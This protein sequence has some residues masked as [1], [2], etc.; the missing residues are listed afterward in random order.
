MFHQVPSWFQSKTRGV[1][2]RQLLA[3]ETSFWQILVRMLKC[4]WWDPWAWAQLL[5]HQWWSSGNG[6]GNWSSIHPRNKYMHDPNEKILPSVT[7]TQTNDICL[8][9]HDVSERCVSL[10]IRLKSC[11][12]VLLWSAPFLCSCEEQKSIPGPVPLACQCL[13]NGK[14]WISVDSNRILHIL[15]IWRHSKFMCLWRQC[16][17]K[18]TFPI[19]RLF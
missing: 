7:S 8:L 11:R 18:M 12:L 3:R 13:E 1:W 19:F 9:I 4:R 5:I 6:H 2:E 14:S 10:Q 17:C 15:F 16:H